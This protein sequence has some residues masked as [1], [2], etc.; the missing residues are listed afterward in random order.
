MTLG[1]IIRYHNLWTV[2]ET[3]FMGTKRMRQVV[4]V[5]VFGLKWVA[6]GSEF[7]FTMPRMT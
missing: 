1:F 2:T 6:Y 3:T 7:V 5:V 4:K